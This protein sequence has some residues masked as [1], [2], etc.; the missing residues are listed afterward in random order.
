MHTK[1]EPLDE[2]P[3]EPKG[4]STDVADVSWVVPTL[5]LS[6]AALTLK[7]ET[8]ASL[9]RSELPVA[10][11]PLP[12]W[13]TRMTVSLVGAIVC[14]TARQSLEGACETEVRGGRKLDFT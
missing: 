7:Q 8:K 2:N 9:P 12:V 3:G 4:G 11:F 1:P 14:G 6:V 10:L 13:P 5:H